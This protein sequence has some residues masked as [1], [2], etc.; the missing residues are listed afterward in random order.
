MCSRDKAYKKKKSFA[1]QSSAFDEFTAIKILREK[2][3]HN[4]EW[5]AIFIRLAQTWKYYVVARAS[6]NRPKKRK[7]PIWKWMESAFCQSGHASRLH[8][9]ERGQE[10][11]NYWLCGATNACTN[12]FKKRHIWHSVRISGTDWHLIARK[13][14]CRKACNDGRNFL[15]TAPRT[16]P[17]AKTPRPPAV[18]ACL[19]TTLHTHSLTQYTESILFYVLCVHTN[20][21][22]NIYIVFLL[23][24]RIFVYA[25]HSVQVDQRLFAL[26][27]HDIYMH[28]I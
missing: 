10:V 13:S 3:I 4:Y 27:S 21:P 2:H 23:K 8:P 19:T 16:K 7:T 11:R 9:N 15:I 12:M 6:N 28:A 14:V 18:F 5:H 24:Q 17:P 20:T 1:R 22:N 25:S 26:T